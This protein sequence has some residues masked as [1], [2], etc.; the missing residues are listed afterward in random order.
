MKKDCAL[1]GTCSNKKKLD[2]MCSCEEAKKT[3]V[4]TSTDN[5]DE[6]WACSMT[7]RGFCPYETKK[8]CSYYHTCVNKIKKD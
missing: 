7:G 1:F 5:M 4:E 2:G 6:K 8:G 3:F